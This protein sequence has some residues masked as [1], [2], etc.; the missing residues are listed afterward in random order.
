MKENF[1]SLQKGSLEGNSSLSLKLPALQARTRLWPNLLG[2]PSILGRGQRMGRR[3]E[4]KL[5]WEKKNLAR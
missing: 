4:T 5:G 2:L 1:R 3:G